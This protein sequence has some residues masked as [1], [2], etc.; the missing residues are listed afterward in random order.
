MTSGLDFYSHM[1]QAGPQRW[2]SPFHNINQGYK[3]LPFCCLAIPKDK[4]LFCKVRPSLLEDLISLQ[5]WTKK[6]EQGQ[7]NDPGIKLLTSA[8]IPLSEMWSFDPTQYKQGWK[9]KS[10][11]VSH[12]PSLHLNKMSKRRVGTVGVL[13][14][15]AT[16]REFRRI[17][18]VR[19]IAN[20]LLQKQFG[21]RRSMATAMRLT[22]YCLPYIYNHH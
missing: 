15:S 2:G 8:H 10:I 7:G 19:A 5:K 1:S 6:G 14:V 11:I 20:V 9:R 18:L 12:V 22:S 16:T 3:P 4:A 17:S 21:P 13:A